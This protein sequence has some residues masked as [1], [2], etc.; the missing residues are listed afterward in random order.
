[1]PVKTEAGRQAWEPGLEL[2]YKTHGIH[3]WV[4][5]V[6]LPGGVVLD[7][8]RLPRPW[9][10]EARE[11]TV[12]EGPYR[13]RVF[14]ENDS[15]RENARVTVKVLSIEPEPEYA[16]VVHE[17]RGGR[18][19]WSAELLRPGGGVEELEVAR[20]VVEDRRER[21][22]DREYYVHVERWYIETPEGEHTLHVEKSVMKFPVVR[23]RREGD[24]IIASGATY[25]V[26]DF[27]K[28]L[29]Y[30][31]D[32]ARKVWYKKTSKPEDDYAE[33]VNYLSNLGAIVE[34]E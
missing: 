7:P 19:E 10:G 17:H 28:N 12:E 9:R 3:T 4:D 32:P 16:V 25:D 22:G 18:M 2:R 15:S 23:L 33:T 13:V 31:W 24:T 27:L 5:Y 29:R 21:R 11:Y 14:V 1:M 6:I 30:R 26:K 20:A 8:R 34:E